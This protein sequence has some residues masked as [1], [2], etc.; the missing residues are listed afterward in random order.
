MFYIQLSYRALLA[1]I[2]ALHH[3]NWHGNLGSNQGR[4]SQSLLCYLYTIPEQKLGIPLGTRT[5]TNGFGDRYAAITS[6][7]QK[8]MVDR[9]RIELLPEACKATVLPLSLTAHTF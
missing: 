1:S 2:Y 7:R 6:E 9:R 4:Q 3:K 8:R 5:P